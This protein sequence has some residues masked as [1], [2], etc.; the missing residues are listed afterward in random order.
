[1]SPQEKRAKARLD[2]HVPLRQ[3][4]AF[5]LSDS[6]ELTSLQWDKA[7]D[8]SSPSAGSSGLFIVTLPSGKVVVKG[9]GDPAKELFACRIGR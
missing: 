7:S 8:L 6:A 4:S 9:S 3:S 5:D 1:M 2:A